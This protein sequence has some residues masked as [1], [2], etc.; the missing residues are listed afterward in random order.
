[1]VVRYRTSY[2]N[3]LW[4]HGI[5]GQK[6]GI[7]RFQNP[8]GSL[9]EAGR[10]RYETGNVAPQIAF[11]K[12]P[13]NRKYER[14]FDKEYGKGAFKKEIDSE[15]ESV[16]RIGESLKK[17]SEEEMKRL[18]FEAANIASVSYDKR[19]ELIDQGK[20]YTREFFE[21][22]RISRIATASAVAAYNEAITR[23]SA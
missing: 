22:D 23:R 9:T 19:Q 15:N 6:W 1:M 7:R 3:E 20:K 18:A 4:H 10:K 2:P 11:D 13:I 21:N 8:D 16:F 12:S 17:A 14:K 5:K